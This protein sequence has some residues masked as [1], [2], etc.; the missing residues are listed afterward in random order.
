MTGQ[1]PSQQ[2]RNQSWFNKTWSVDYLRSQVN[3]WDVQGTGYIYPWLQEIGIVP[4]YATWDNV[5]SAYPLLDRS[6]IK[7]EHLASLAVE[8]DREGPSYLT[9]WLD[10][11]EFECAGNPKRDIVREALEAVGELSGRRTSRSD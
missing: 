4:K 1:T 9:E 7:G 2:E 11:V 8:W 10:M 5:F 6:A 3:Y